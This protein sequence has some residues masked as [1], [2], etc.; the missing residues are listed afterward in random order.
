M[1]DIGNI[2]TKNHGLVLT[3]RFDAMINR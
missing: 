1:I 3:P 2:D